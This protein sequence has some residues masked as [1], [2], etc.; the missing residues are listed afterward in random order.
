M[1]RTQRMVAALTA[2][3]AS[4]V[5]TLPAHADVVNGGFETGTFA[6]WT[7]TGDTSFSGVDAFAARTGSFGAF[8]GPTSVGGISQ[9]F[10]TLAGVPYLVEFALAL[11]DSAQPN[12]FSWTWNG[13]TQ[14]PTL[15]NVAGF[16]YSN[17]SAMVTAV[18]ASSSIGFT[19]SNPQSFWLL[20]NVRVTA[21]P[22]PPVTALLAAGLV[23]LA[24]SL[25]RR[26]KSPGSR[27]A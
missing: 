21:V 19:F 15:T 13:A 14:T 27:E 6:G 11:Q 2:V 5:M 23:L 3:I 20:D 25:K 16:G 4:A 17:F 1:N 24:R 22:E 12:G 9:S 7:Q 10:A 18:G 26:A 8:F